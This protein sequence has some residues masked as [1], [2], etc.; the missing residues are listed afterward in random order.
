[1]AFCRWLSAKTGKT[2]DLPTEA[3]WEYG[4]RAG[5]R[6]RFFTGDDPGSLEGYANRADQALKGAL[7]PMQTVGWEFAPW[8]DGYAFTAPVG[9]FKPNAFGLY[10]MHGNAWEW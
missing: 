3:E 8:N 4:C 7:D 2:F 6:T 10:D 5:A 9:S 1:M